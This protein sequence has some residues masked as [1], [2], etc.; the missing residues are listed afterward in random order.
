MDP[1]VPEFVSRADVDTGWAVLPAGNLSDP[2]ASSNLGELASVEFESTGGLAAS[3]LSRSVDVEEL[4][5]G[6][7]LAPPNV[8]VETS[9]TL[10]AGR[11]AARIVVSRP[12]GSGGME[13][14]DARPM[15]Y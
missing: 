6:D 4:D 15:R 1:F 5:K 14:A 11:G 10:S 12:F 3:A 7:D 8:C 9:V 13:A 2:T